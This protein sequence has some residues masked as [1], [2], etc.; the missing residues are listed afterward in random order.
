MCQNFDTPSLLSKKLSYDELL[1]VLDEQLTFALVSN[2]TA[3]QV[4]A[5]SSA[6]V[7]NINHNLADATRLLDGEQELHTGS[8]PGGLV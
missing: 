1:A 3:L 4:E 6:G 8:E 5:L 2:A 7:V